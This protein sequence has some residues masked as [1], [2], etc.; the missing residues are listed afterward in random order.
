MWDP[1]DNIKPLSNTVYVYLRRWLHP[2]LPHL[3]PLAGDFNSLGR[4]AQPSITQG[5]ACQVTAA[6]HPGPTDQDSLATLYLVHCHHHGFR[7]GIGENCD[8]FCSG[9]TDAEGHQ[10]ATRHLKGGGNHDGR[11]IGGVTKAEMKFEYIAKTSCGKLG[12]WIR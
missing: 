6:I 8:L 12:A 9:S 1:A 2:L 4:S 10:L 7:I 5:E 3:S 11:I